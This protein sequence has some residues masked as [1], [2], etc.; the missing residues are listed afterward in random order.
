[1]AD[2]DTMRLLGHTFTKM[3][4]SDWE[5][6][7]GADEG[8]FIVYLEPQSNDDPCVLIYSPE[9]DILTSICEDGTEFNWTR[10]VAR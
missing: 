9:K 2:D 7:S 3:D 10:R 8:S 6:F 5:A 4:V 1:M